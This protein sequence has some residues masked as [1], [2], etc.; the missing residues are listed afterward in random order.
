[1]NLNSYAIFAI[2]N[3]SDLHTVAKFLRY[4]DT[5][6]A[7]KKL[8]FTP[9]LCMG[10]YNGMAE[11]SYFMSLN[12]FNAFVRHSGYVDNQTCVLKLHPRTPRTI[13]L[14]GYLEY[15][16]TGKEESVGDWKETEDPYDYDYFTIMDG[17]CFVCW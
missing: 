8:S 9:K 6:R 2:D 12:D 4:L 1:M 17:K 13:A 14:T 3:D 10:M 7:M 11:Q 15:F 16:K 5:L